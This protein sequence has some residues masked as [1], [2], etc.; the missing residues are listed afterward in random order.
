MRPWV[1]ILTTTV[2]LTGH[3]MAAERGDIPFCYV[4]GLI[5]VE[6]RIAGAAE[7]L[8]FLLDSGAAVSVLNSGVAQRLGMHDGQSVVVKGLGG[9]SRGRWPQTMSASA[10][11]VPLPA[12]Y[13]V[14]DLGDL[15][16]SC[17]S[18]VDGLIGAD[19][20]EGRV[21]EI[22]FRR[23]V[24]RLISPAAAASEAETLPSILLKKSR[25]A[26]TLEAQIDGAAKQHLRLDTGCATGLHWVT[27][28]VPAAATAR[29]SVGLAP[30][31]A[32]MA[33]CELRLGKETWT[34][35]P[36]TLHAK[37]IFPGED[38]LLGNE[39]LSRHDAVILDGCK[40]R[41]LLGA[42]RRD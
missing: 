27:G 25:G 32:P 16:E 8:W 5:R 38:G 31:A 28:S 14:V 22:D 11:G 21:V 12:R 36:A 15:Q 39:F 34:G 35:V 33:Q 26:W 42:V 41:L 18:R 19:F 2:A 6:V 13:L 29:L 9:Q 37:R 20:F 23:N 40:G 1:S 10:H 30:F 4:D 3:A 7:P 24:L 17:S